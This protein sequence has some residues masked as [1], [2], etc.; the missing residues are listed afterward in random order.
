LKK[1]NTKQQYADLELMVND[2][3]L[4]QKHV[5]LY[6][7]VMFYT[8]DT[9]QPVEIVIDAISKDQIRG[10]VRTSEDRRSEPALRS[11]NTPQPCNPIEVSRQRTPTCWRS[12]ALV[13]DEQ[14]P[15]A[16]EI[17]QQQ[18]AIWLTQQ[19]QRM[20]SERGP[21]KRVGANALRSTFSIRLKESLEKALIGNQRTNS[22][23]ALIEVC[24]KVCRA[25]RSTMRQIEPFRY[26]ARALPCGL[27]LEVSD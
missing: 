12:R 2:Q 25:L 23:V 7:P 18:L 8:P 21:R 9:S 10:Y 22:A 5:N 13:L 4:S 6:Q 20:L 15:V 14:D 1:A 19:V 27:I 11:N 17:A 16:P 3:S 26:F 24:R